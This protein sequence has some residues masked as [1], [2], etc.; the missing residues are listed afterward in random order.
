VSIDAGPAWTAWAMVT[1]VV[2]APARR[3]RY[4]RAPI[5]LTIEP[6]GDGGYP[7]LRVID[8]NGTE[9][10]Y[11]IDPERATPAAR[12]LALID[13]GF[14]EHRWTQAVLDLGASHD[15]VDTIRLSIDVAAR[16][17]Y[18]ETV[19]IDASDDHVT[20]RVVRGDAIVYRVAQDGGRGDRTIWFAPTRSRWLRVR[21]LDPRAP[22]PLTGAS[23]ERDVPAEDG[24]MPVV[25][26]GKGTAAAT[27]HDRGPNSDVTWTFASRVAIRPAAVTFHDQ[28]EAY[29]RHAVVQSSDD[30]AEWSDAGDAQIARFGGGAQTS[31]A[32][33]E[34][35]A[36]YWRV[37]VHNGSDKP[38][39]GLRPV[40]LGHT[41]YVVF[42]SAAGTA[43]RLL[44]GNPDAVAPTYDLRER[45]AHGTWRAD[46]AVPRSSTLANASFRDPRPLADR[47]PPWLLSTALA[48][49]AALLG[50]LAIRTVR[51]AQA[52]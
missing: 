42:A 29:V 32:F 45:L 35:T 12:E 9:L 18:F 46:R 11:A 7:D 5:P 23:I 28:G 39:E 36:R 10:A 3:E 48:I 2:V 22:F 21:I 24:L 49:V 33:D 40:L 14:V 38:V 4:V 30:G 17:T 8:G 51:T 15:L 1:P 43:Y 25:V 41:H 27:P 19:A 26:F 34:R 13:R 52:K 20:W 50:F 31:F 6:N 44:S 47:L 37:V 16:P